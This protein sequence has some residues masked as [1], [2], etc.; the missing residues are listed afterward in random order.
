MARIY[1]SS[2]YRDLLGERQAVIN[3][4]RILGHTVV[5]MEEYHA[6]DD[7]PLDRCRDDVRTCQG[8][9]SIV[10]FRYGFIPESHQESI[11]ELEY[12]TASEPGKRRRDL[13]SQSPRRI[14]P[15]AIVLA[16]DIFL[17]LESPRI[18]LVVPLVNAAD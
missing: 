2:T 14:A 11:T 10:A 16:A 13:C 1:V 6:K 8:L 17:M 4:V 12:L 3:A 7:R 5:T 18:A 15:K 9:I